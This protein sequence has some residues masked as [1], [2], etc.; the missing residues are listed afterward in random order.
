M[1]KLLHYDPQTI[2]NLPLHVV[3]DAVNL[4]ASKRSAVVAPLVLALS[5]LPQ[6][7]IDEARRV[8]VNAVIVLGA[9]LWLVGV[10]IHAS[11]RRSVG[12]RVVS[13]IRRQASVLNDPG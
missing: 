7:I 8:E 13:E 12:D 11:L 1:K 6:V 2:S 4:C 9:A 5:H 10:L 3:K